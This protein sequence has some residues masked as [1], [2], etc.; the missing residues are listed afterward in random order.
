[1]IYWNKADYVAELNKVLKVRE[2][3]KALE[4]HKNNE[5]EYL[6]LSSI[7]GR[8]WYFDITNY[9]EAQI[10]HTVGLVEAGQKPHN[11]ITSDT[12]IMRIAKTM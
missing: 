8:A 10:L 9:D 3:H 12:R 5:G 6:I 1:M 4:Y 7:V 11:L 2:D